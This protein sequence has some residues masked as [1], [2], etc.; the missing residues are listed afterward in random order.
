MYKSGSSPFQA[1]TMARKEGL[2]LSGAATASGAG[3]FLDNGRGHCSE[4]DLPSYDKL[5]VKPDLHRPDSVI[6]TSSIVSSEGGDVGAVPPAPAPDVYTISGLYGGNVSHAPS[7]DPVQPVKTHKR[8][9][10]S[11]AANII[12]GCQMTHKRSH[13][14]TVGYNHKRTGS[15]GF[16]P[17]HR[18][19]ASGALIEALDKMTGGGLEGGTT[20]EYLQS[21]REQLKER[22]VSVEEQE[23]VEDDYSTLRDCGYMA[24]KPHCAQPLASIK[25]FV[26]LLSMLVTLQQALSSGY[27][28]SVITTIEKRYEISSSTS[29]LIASMYEI[30]NVGTV[31]FVSYLGTR[32][33][34]PMF[35]GSG[36][37][38]MGIGSIIFS[39]PHFL[40][41]SYSSTFDYGP[42]MTDT[43]ICRS[44][45]IKPQQSVMEQLQLGEFNQ[46]LETDSLGNQLNK[47]DNCTKE[48]SK[49]SSFHIFIFMLAQLF[50][51][52]GGSPLLTLG[53]TY[54][55][56]HVRR[57]AASVY[58]GF[59]YSMVAFGPVLGFLLGGYLLSQ[60]VDTFSIDVS[61]LEIDTGSR[62]W[63]GMWWGGFL[64][65]GSL[66]ILISIPFFAFPKDLKREKRKIYLEEKFKKEENGNK[67]KQLEEKE[68]TAGEEY[69]KNL[70]DLPRCI[71]KLLT[72][73]IYLVTCMG[74]C[75]ELVIVSGF[76]VFLPKYLETQFALSKTEAPILTGATAIP[77]A[78]IGIFLGGYILKKLQLGPK[79]AIQLVI[80][81]NFFCLCCYGLLFV[82]GC[83]NIKMAG[84]TSPYT[85]NSTQQ[86]QVS[87]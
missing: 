48:G 52:C 16:V 71:W 80:F 62:H 72:N 33:H 64:I 58:I 67:S 85:I 70:K 12:R 14:H 56:N 81:F 63:V 57:D 86:F 21:M 69:G 47:E 10:S 18:R 51:G 65:C 5:P 7:V 9:T 41:E 50:L 78:C 6:T 15:V 45:Y 35:I 8:S 13:S 49:S 27:L 43:N 26:M 4:L 20:T 29:G 25:V 3:N 84:A 36:V 66:M 76:I 30:G 53:T 24:C 54:I 42:N 31:I 17:G 73:W 83:S 22:R 60:Y 75:M 55:D 37:I 40:S 44:P 61:T 68:E 2:K 38:I 87:N 32:R 46:L 39:L 23:E 1:A 11:T 19:T 59:M 28:N 74:A 82:L 34:I 77:G 79:G